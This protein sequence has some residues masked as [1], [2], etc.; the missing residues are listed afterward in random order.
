L[1]TGEQEGEI[2]LA[3]SEDGLKWDYKQ[4]VLNE[5]FH[6]SYPYVFEWQVRF[7]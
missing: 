3:T 7:S 5:P 4:V 6:L 1:L 2:G